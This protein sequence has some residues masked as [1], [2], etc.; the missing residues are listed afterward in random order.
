MD[1]E[2]LKMLVRGCPPEKK[3]KLQP[4]NKTAITL[5]DVSE[6]ESFVIVLVLWV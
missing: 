4:V 3:K 1:P 2:W 5:R 6:H